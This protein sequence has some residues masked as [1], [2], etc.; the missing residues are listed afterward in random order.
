MTEVSEYRSVL[1]RPQFK[2]LLHNPWFSSERRC[3]IDRVTE[4]RVS[5]LARA[6]GNKLGVAAFITSLARCGQW[7][8]IQLSN[9]HK[10][11]RPRHCILEPLIASPRPCP[12]AQGQKAQVHRLPRCCQQISACAAGERA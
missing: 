4:Y 10:H 5:D 9:V 7:T 3:F 12:V 2:N 8:P 1:R 11:L 6:E